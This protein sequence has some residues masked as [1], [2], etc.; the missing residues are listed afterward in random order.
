MSNSVTDYVLH[1]KIADAK[2]VVLE[3]IEGIAKWCEGE[4]GVS[5]EVG[6][7]GQTYIQVD[8]KHLPPGPLNRAYVGDWII[9]NEI[10]YKILSDEEY[11]SIFRV[12]TMNREKF[13]KTLRLV[14]LAMIEQDAHTLH[15]GEK[16]MALV[17]EDI[18]IRIMEL[19]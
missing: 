4:I 13:A 17:A 19:D 11:R 12:V 6:G 2:C 8:V 3:D 15:H 18:A 10:G 16:D 9:T 5:H 1:N 14:R 7:E